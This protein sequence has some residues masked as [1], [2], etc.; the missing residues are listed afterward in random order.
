MRAG[1]DS[2]YQVAGTRK[3]NFVQKITFHAAQ[4]PG[5][6]RMRKE[7]WIDTLA[8]GIARVGIDP[9]PGM[10][11]RGN[12]EIVPLEGGNVGTVAA[13]F[14]RAT[15]SSAD[16][17]ADSVNS[18]I[19]LLNIG[20]SPLQ[21]SQS[22]RTAYIGSGEAVV[23]DLAEPSI[24]YAANHDMSRLLSIEVARNLVRPQFAGF[25]DRLM[26]PIPAQSG[27]LMLARTYA[28]TL[29]RP[30]NAEATP[31]LARLAAEHLSE[32]VAAALAGTEGLGAP[33]AGGVRAA[34]LA[35]VQR[36]IERHFMDPNFSLAVLAR[37]VGVTP[38]YVQAL[39]AETGSSF[40]N[41]VTERRLQRAYSMLAS[42]H[43]GRLSVGEIAFA[44][45]FSTISH[46]HRVFRHR[47]AATPGD[48]RDLARSERRNPTCLP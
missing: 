44:C 48:V 38:R 25:E 24:A 21:L 5:V 4:L 7:A 37:R 13:T 22:G 10:R 27:A 33:S 43:L 12:I 15:R 28:E 41:V 11:F 39:L 32:L 23:Y 18:V 42:P 45:G 46:F 31:H 36:E 17:A 6:D 3:E 20:K 9:V 14:R 1:G 8:S 30:A 35:A 16:I 47:F 26:R 2:G 19:L 29:L 40:G 34:H